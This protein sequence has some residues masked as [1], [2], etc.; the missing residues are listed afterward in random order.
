VRLLRSSI[1]VILDG[2]VDHRAGSPDEE[3]HHYSAQI[4]GRAEALI[5]GRVTYELMESAW[6]PPLEESG[7]PEWTR[8]F[9]ET[10]SRAKKY[11]V[12]S[13]LPSV[14]WN[15]E[16]ITGDVVDAV[17]HLKEAPGG[18]LYVG[19][20]TLPR[21]LVAAAGARRCRPH[22]RI[23]V[24]RAADGRRPWAPSAGRPADST[25]VDTDEFATV[26]RWSRRHDSCTDRLRPRPPEP[27]PPETCLAPTIR[28][29]SRPTGKRM[30]HGLPAAHRSTRPALLP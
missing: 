30:R 27:R 11:V 13:T 17:R 28:L 7:F 15:A 2:C 22:R 16:L 20:V 29:W 19:G 18:E 23:R 6:R 12:S 9:A 26:L 14:D 10:I 1:N 21:A 4:I 5:L 25:D 24:H 3:L 8:P